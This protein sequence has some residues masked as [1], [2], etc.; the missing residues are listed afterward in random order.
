M[1]FAPLPSSL[2]R[3]LLLILCGSGGVTCLSGEGRA[4]WQ[5]PQ[6]RSVSEGQ[7]FL[8]D[9]FPDGFL[10]GA[11]SSA[12]QTEGS[13]SRDG[14]G[15]SVWDRF[16]HS[17]SPAA[18]AD[19]ASDSYRLWE[20]DV[21]A[22][23]Y[24]GASSYA[25]SLSWPRLFPNGTTSG[26]PNA[27]G[28]AHY[29]RMI[30]RLR[31]EG[32]EPVVTLFHWDLPLALQEDY[33]G[34][35]NESL[36]DVFN[37]Y[38]AFCF[39]TYGSRVK[40]WI[41]MHNPYLLAW[42]GYRTGLHA[43]GESHD[44]SATF[45]VAHNL[46][47]AHANVWHTY[48]SHFRPHQRGYVSI[49]LG[50]H[51]IQPIR[52]QASPSNVERCQESMEAVVGW[53][54]E[55]IHGGGDYPASLKRQNPRLLPEF[56]EAERLQ[57]RGTADFFA[58]SFGPDNIRLGPT[59]TQ[60]GQQVSL[61]LRQAL[62]WVKLEYGN[63]RVLIAENGWFSDATVGTN[64]T[65]AI[66]L[67][68]KFTNQVLQAIVH[69]SVQVFG[70]TAWSLV[71]GFEWRY[72][73]SVRRGLF[74]VD[75]NS[76]DRA[77][78][79]KTSARFYRGVIADHGYP[80]SD[81]TRDVKG[82]FPCD[83]HWGVADSTL[84]VRLRPFS[85]QFTDPHLYCWNMSG[86]GVL[87]PVEG[88]HLQTRGAQCSDFLAIQKH[89][90]LLQATG[91]DHYRFALNWSLILPRGDLSAVNREAL[92][93]YRCVV[94][95]AR[96]R[97]IQ[98][99]VTLYYPT[100]HPPLL[101]LPAPLHDA[102]GW[103]NGSTVGAFREYA[104]LCFRELGPWVP[105]WITINEPNRLSQAYNA[106][107]PYRAAHHLILAHAAA[108]R[109]YDGEFR[110]QQ[111]ALVSFS[112]HADWAEPANPFLESHAA[113]AR[114]FL[115]F[116]L[117]C[118]LEPFLGGRG[119]DAARRGGEYPAEV[120]EYLR[121]KAS[122][123]LSRSSLPDFTEPE[124]R[125]V[126]GALDFI[127]LNHFTTRL[128]S[129]RRIN[130][131]LSRSLDHD[132]LL[133]SDPTWP[134]SDLGQALVPWGL[135][136]VLRWLSE[137]YAE[138]SIFITA[139]GVDDPASK[140][141]QLR[142]FYLRSY[143]QEALKAYQVDGVNLRGFYAWKLQDRHGPQFGLFSSFHHQSVPKASV[144]A[145]REIIARRG[146]PETDRGASCER[147]D[148]RTPCALCHVVLGNGPLLFFVVC[149]F[150]T[151]TLL[152]AVVFLQARRKK[153]GQHRAAPSRRRRQRGRVTLW[154]VPHIFNDSC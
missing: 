117:A 79:P 115:L 20:E 49:T 46:I 67:M 97:D 32:I 18:T 90:D 104:E 55:P 78:L 109:L 154:R 143:L 118:F 142:Q 81:E 53:F 75:F 114:R 4:L 33:G 136:R 13:C 89:L 105:L 5:Q 130:S 116:E 21:A 153:T 24:L 148:A 111:G 30:D 124:R 47:R 25:F 31:E 14:K 44:A 72:G 103:L 121:E 119:G 6:A 17:R 122:V 93:Y 74:Y 62:N 113:A 23:K 102:G 43:P 94:K 95:E 151:L 77:R 22:L 150:L 41:T 29:S 96:K 131:S 57:V 11:G 133:L 37:D 19:V 125:E 2:S 15:P 54:A 138:A 59:L 56:T 76:P 9:T 40:Y 129:Y 80:S 16:S 83:F 71:D 99:M 135:R 68:K 139:S 50:S 140:D 86:N 36:V 134:S 152:I 147:A 91:A 1:A 61:D 120:R 146:D 26:G 100:H 127:A 112:L 132:C 51:W 64:D 45:T 88:V 38:A 12:F 35:R 126:L 108:W 52:R 107:D 73:Y 137:R 87:S 27:A 48:D 7:L 144:S 3:F 69:D 82:Q 28:V 66:Y 63:P 85:P 101:G 128:V 123:G 10:W 106:S 145:Y 60:Y 34:W 110:A 70:Y 58:L 39:Q 42:Q 141:D 149:V 8:L 98:P 84:Q 65:V 92:R